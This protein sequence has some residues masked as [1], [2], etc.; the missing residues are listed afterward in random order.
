MRDL[1]SWPSLDAGLSSRNLGPTLWRSSVQG[2]YKRRALGCMKL[3][4][5]LRVAMTRDLATWGLP[6]YHPC[7][8]KSTTIWTR[9]M[10][11]EGTNTT[12]PTGGLWRQ[13][14]RLHRTKHA[15]FKKKLSRRHSRS[16]FALRSFFSLNQS[17]PKGKGNKKGKKCQSAV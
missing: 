1:T 14:R 9:T 12:K 6:F 10:E 16:S 17:H 4:S 8:V 15:F 7:K 13:L 2:W 3:P 5:R 11:R